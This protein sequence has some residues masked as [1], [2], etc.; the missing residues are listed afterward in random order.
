VRRHHGSAAAVPARLPVIRRLTCQRLTRSG[1]RCQP[2]DD[3]Q[4]VARASSGSLRQHR[5]T[6]EHC[7]IALVH[8]HAGV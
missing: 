3:E 1:F 2:C 7:S 6:V 5:A 4:P 8:G